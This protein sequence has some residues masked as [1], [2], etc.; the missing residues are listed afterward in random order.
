M[1]ISKFGNIRNI[2]NK[3]CLAAH[4]FFSV[5]V[6]SSKMPCSV[7]PTRSN[8]NNL[9][10]TQ[11]N[12]NDVQP[13]RCS[14]R[15]PQQTPELGPSYQPQEERNN[16]PASAWRPARGSNRRTISQPQQALNHATR[17]CHGKY[18]SGK[19]S[20]RPDAIVDHTRTALSQAQTS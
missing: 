10:T 13:A 2:G 11:H 5:V 7:Q 12:L 9:P 14:S 18:C 19:M 1:E 4:R 17:S 3:I 16:T 15:V 6:S 8:N 20:M